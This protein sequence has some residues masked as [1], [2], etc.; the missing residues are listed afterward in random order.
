MQQKS[1]VVSVL[2][3]MALAIAAVPTGTA[4]AVDDLTPPVVSSVAVSP[5]PAAIGNLVTVTATVDDTLTGG[6]NIVAAAFSVDG[7]AYA[8]MTAS[9]GA[10]NSPIESVTGSFSASALGSSHICVQGTDAA[11]WVSE[12]VCAELTIQSQIVFEGFSPPIKSGN[13]YVR[14]GR[15]IP[16]KFTLET[17]DGTPISDLATYEGIY[18]YEVDCDTLV[19]DPA[20]AVQ[21]SGPGSTALGVRLNGQWIGLWKTPKSY[22]DSCRLMY[23]LFS[24][25]SMSPEVLFRFR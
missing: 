16:L 12:V 1:R 10:F 17:P 24:D 19:G 11:G 23:V 15:A 25:G 14:A 18:S 8:P 7:G 21:E 2:L 4:F 9:D 13:N 3:A 22:A 20:T 6:S 5:N